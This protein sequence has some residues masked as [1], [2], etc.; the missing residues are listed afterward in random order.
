MKM[1]FQTRQVIK[2]TSSTTRSGNNLILIPT[3]TYPGH[4]FPDPLKIKVIPT[5][6]IDVHINA[7]CIHA[8]YVIHRLQYQNHKTFIVVTFSIVFTGVDSCIEKF[9]ESARHL[10]GYFAKYQMYSTVNHPQDAIR[11]VILPLD[12]A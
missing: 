4:L 10:E 2:H 1:M 7:V 3:C 8:V 5:S 9:L 11:E 12:T 6:A